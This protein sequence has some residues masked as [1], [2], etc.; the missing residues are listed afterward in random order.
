[1]AVLQETVG[2]EAVVLT[3]H[4][5]APEQLTWA[6]IDSAYVRVISGGEVVKAKRGRGFHLEGAEGVRAFVRLPLTCAMCSSSAFC[7]THRPFPW[8]LSRLCARESVI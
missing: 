2:W 5:Y 8:S 7:W 4:I 1:M 3:L 6:G